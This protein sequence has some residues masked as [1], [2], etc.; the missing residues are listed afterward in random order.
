MKHRLIGHQV[1]S[2][3]TATE[4]P[5]HPREIFQTA[6]RRGAVRVI[7]AHNHPSGSLE[8][9]RKLESRAPQCI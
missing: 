8:P 7:V 2:I 1:I 5:V 9:I 6:L 3:G 4:A